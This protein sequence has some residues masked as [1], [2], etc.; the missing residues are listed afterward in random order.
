[1]S[2]RP[3]P[4]RTHSPRPPARSLALTPRRRSRSI[5]ITVVSDRPSACAVETASASRRS[6][7]SDGAPPPS[8]GAS[9]VSIACVTENG[10]NPSRDTVRPSSSA[11]S[12]AGLWRRRHH[13]PLDRPLLP[14]TAHRH[15][16]RHE[17]GVLRLVRS[18]S[19]GPQPRDPLDVSGVD[20]GEVQ[21]GHRQGRGVSVYPDTRI[22]IRRDAAPSPIGV[23]RAR[24]WPP[25]STP[26]RF[27]DPKG[28]DLSEFIALHSWVRFVLRG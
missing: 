17:R 21:H 10:F 15:Q 23:S 8:S 11:A 22:A 14:V 13:H 18:G 12:H 27:C 9:H 1:M 26:E 7:R 6:V 19:L 5:P 20:L 3:A 4:P 28:H 25:R 16:H 2:P 24:A